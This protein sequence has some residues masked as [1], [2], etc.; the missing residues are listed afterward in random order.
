MNG[1]ATEL[2]A[3]LGVHEFALEVMMA[4]WLAAMPEAEAERFL[5]DFEKRSRSAYMRDTAGI[6]DEAVS[7]VMQGTQQIMGDFLK[8]VRN[9]LSDIRT[10]V[11]ERE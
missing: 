11:G 7:Q 4:N 5:Q 2:Y 8:K 9:R 10:Q 1:T 6:D 3:R